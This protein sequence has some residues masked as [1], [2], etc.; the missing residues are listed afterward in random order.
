MLK[1]KKKKEKK[2]IVLVLVCRNSRYYYVLSN[3]QKNVT[4]KKKKKKPKCNKSNRTIK[5]TKEMTTA[6]PFSSKSRRRFHTAF[7]IS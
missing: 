2:K 6:P 4:K 7:L 1:M 3:L 5:H